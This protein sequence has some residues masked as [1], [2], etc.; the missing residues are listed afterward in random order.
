MPC[1]LI[2]ALGCLN[3][4]YVL[5]LK[6]IERQWRVLLWRNN[7]RNFLFKFTYTKS[8]WEKVKLKIIEEMV[9]KEK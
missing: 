8:T 9:V 6:G 1:D 3:S 5:K 4:K 2:W 7:I